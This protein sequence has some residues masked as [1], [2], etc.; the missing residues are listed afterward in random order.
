MANKLTPDEQ[1]ALR[2]NKDDLQ[3]HKDEL[4]KFRDLSS[5]QTTPGGKRLIEALV[6]NIINTMW[7][8]SNSDKDPLS[9][10]LKANLDLLALLKGAKENEEA[11]ITDIKEALNVS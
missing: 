8:L 2:F 6:E 5:L 9:A 10:D 7:K 11:V 3:G 1:E 4:D